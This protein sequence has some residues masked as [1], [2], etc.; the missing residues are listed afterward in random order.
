MLLDLGSQE[1][2]AA[3][4]LKHGWVC[5]AKGLLIGA[6]THMQ[7][8]DIGLE[9][10]RDLHAL[11]EIIAL[12]HELRAGE[13]QL[14]RKARADRGADG[15]QHLEQFEQLVAFGKPVFIDKPLACSYQ[16]AKAILDLSKKSGVPFMT[17][18][19]MRY[20]PGVA[21]LCPADE[22]IASAEGFG[23][24]A[25][26]D[27]Y[28]DYFWY[29]I[30]TAETIYRYLGVGCETVETLSRGDTEIILGTWKDGRTGLCVGNRSG[31]YCFGARILTDKTQHAST[32][33]A[34]VS[35]MGALS[36]AMVQFFR[37]GVSPISPEES[38]E[39]I[40]FLEAAS[41]SRAQK[42]KPVNL[43]EL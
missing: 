24:L 15:L 5:D 11:L 43:S 41:R 26:L 38:V 31:A 9:D 1:H 37:T 23:P 21:D 35:Y 2:V 16:D 28:R 30:H 4:V 32:I 19:S 39:V 20:A 13:A 42:G 25:F 12:G 8:V 29:G 3:V 10:L 17:A 14:D 18:S 34:N 6:C 7:Q 27:D 40:A 22:K 33:N 36:Q